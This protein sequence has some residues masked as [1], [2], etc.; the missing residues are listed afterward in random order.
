M[1]RFVF[2]RKFTSL[3]LS[4]VALGEQGGPG[5]PRRAAAVLGMA[6]ASPARAQGGGTSPWGKVRPHDHNQLWHGLGVT[7]QGFGHRLRLGWDGSQ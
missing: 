4:E 6:G 5:I 1:E 2:D 3:K 7:R